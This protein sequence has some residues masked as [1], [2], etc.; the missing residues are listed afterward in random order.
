MNVNVTGMITAETALELRPP[1]DSDRDRTY[2]LQVG[3]SL[4]LFGDAAQLGRL[5]DVLTAGL[6]TG[7]AA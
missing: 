7:G 2:S 4:Y 3:D 1:R 5:R 6:D